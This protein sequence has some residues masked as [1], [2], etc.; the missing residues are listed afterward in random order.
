[1]SFFIQT[2]SIRSELNQLSGKTEQLP[3]YSLE[4]SKRL[5]AGYENEFMVSNL[6]TSFSSAQKLGRLSDFV[7]QVV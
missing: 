5:L 1:M 4:R 2:T 7:N 6:Q 3:V